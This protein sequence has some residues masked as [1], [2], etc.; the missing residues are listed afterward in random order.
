[1]PRGVYKQ[2]TIRKMSVELVD[3]LLKLWA[4]EHVRT[5]IAPLSSAKFVENCQPFYTDMTFA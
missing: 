2:K 5:R 1:M 3:E 4:L